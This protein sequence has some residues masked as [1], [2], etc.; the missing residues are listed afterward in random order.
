MCYKSFQGGTRFFCSFRW[1][2]EWH[3]AIVAILQQG[4]Y[5]KCVKLALCGEVEEE[6][7]LGLLNAAARAT[8]VARLR[9]IEQGFDEKVEGLLERKKK[10]RQQRRTKEG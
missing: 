2:G 3:D 4:L 6:A 5:L 1:I 10:S 8:R 7:V 9:L